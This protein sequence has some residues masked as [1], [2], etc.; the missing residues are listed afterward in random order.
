[1][2][3]LQSLL[4]TFFAFVTLAAAIPAP[5]MD[6]SQLDARAV[7]DEV[8]AREPNVLHL[9]KDIFVRTLINVLLLNTELTRAPI[10][11]KSRFGIF[12]NWCSIREPYMYWIACSKCVLGD[13]SQLYAWWGSWETAPGHHIYR[14]CNSTVT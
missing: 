6:G 1:M 10:Y 11:R 13:G 2:P 12:I 5:Q 4:L 14:R 3:S 7:D 8:V 9:L